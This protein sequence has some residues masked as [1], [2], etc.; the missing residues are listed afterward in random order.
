MKKLMMVLFAFVVSVTIGFAEEIPTVV[1]APFTAMEGVEQSEVNIIQ[2]MFT[3]QY[4][5]TKKAKVVDRSKF[6]LIQEQMKFQSSDCSNSDKVAEFG[7]ALNAA[8]VVTGEFTKY[9]KGVYVNIQVLDVNT[10]MIVS[11][12]NPPLTVS[13][14]LDVIDKLPEICESLATQAVGEIPQKKV[15]DGEIKVATENV[16]QKQKIAEENKK[17]SQ[18]S[19]K[20]ISERKYY[21]IGDYDSEHIGRVYN[22]SG[23][24]AYVFYV[25]KDSK[26]HTVE[27]SYEEA[28]TTA[29]NFKDGSWRLIDYNEAC[30]LQR[31]CYEKIDFFGA[32]WTAGY[33]YWIPRKDCWI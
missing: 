19:P 3:S 6:N 18:S 16:E 21:S 13:E 15:S 2:S 14:T 4:A 10:T 32:H 29:K 17:S 22:T 5:G 30:T 24:T 26:D 11:S 25:I 27:L 1:I 7:R 8:H 20:T 23:S 28:L 9:A 33:A 31:H 12:I